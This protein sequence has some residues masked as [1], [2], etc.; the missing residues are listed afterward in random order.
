SELQVQKTGRGFALIMDDV[1][2]DVRALK[3]L[4]KLNVPLA[5]S[6]LPDAPFARQS[7]RLAN[8]AGQVVMLHLPM[9]PESSSHH[10][11]DSF[12]H[13]DMNEQALRDTLLQNIR[14]VPFVEGVN[15]HMGSKLT[16]LSEPMRWVMQVCRENNLFFVDSRTS[17]NSVAAKAAKN[18]G[19]AWA[20]RQIFLDHEMKT[21][22]MLQAWQKTRACVQKGHRCIVIG[23][24]RSKTITFL[25]NH[26]SP[27]DAANMVSIKR[28]LQKNPMQV[29]QQVTASES[30][31]P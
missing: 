13:A 28:L 14:Q 7:A 21:E 24:P 30:L 23:H 15:N 12:L 16:Q 18:S 25:E 9:Q 29:Q 26:L 8:Q 19:L 31:L 20:S 1:G 4:L 22:A 2:Y 3:R 11:T 10:L 17:P 6:V 5:V 27:E